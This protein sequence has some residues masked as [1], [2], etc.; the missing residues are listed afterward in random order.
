MYYTLFYAY[1][2]I[3]NA[4]TFA[5]MGI[6]KRKA[7]NH[8]RRVPERTLFT[9]AALGG[10]LGGVAGMKAFRHKTKHTKFKVGFPLLLILHIALIA[11]IALHKNNVI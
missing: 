4:V 2:A 11:A 3:I 10:S 7:V 8:T 5:V 6:D 1:L 9:L